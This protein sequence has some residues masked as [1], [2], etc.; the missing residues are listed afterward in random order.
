MQH[1]EERKAGEGRAGDGLINTAGGSGGGGRGRRVAEGRVGTR[2]RDVIKK[3]RRGHEGTTFI[4]FLI[5]VCA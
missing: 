5:A 4:I 3:N 2:G 1:L